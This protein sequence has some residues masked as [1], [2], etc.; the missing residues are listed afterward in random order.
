MFF[1]GYK[2]SFFLFEFLDLAVFKLLLI[3][4]FLLIFNVLNNELIFMGLNFAGLLF[5][6]K[7]M[8]C[9]ISLFFCSSLF[10]NIPFLSERKKGDISKFSFD[11]IKEPLCLL[12]ILEV[13]LCFKTCSISDNLLFFGEE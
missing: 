11:K 8:F 1:F 10:A 5:L 13:S 7:F 9:L 3:E 6:I 2:C 4:L 12:L